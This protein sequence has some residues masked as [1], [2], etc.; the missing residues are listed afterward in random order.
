MNK[1]KKKDFEAFLF[2]FRPATGFLQKKKK[3]KK[4]GEKKITQKSLVLGD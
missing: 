2:M 4:K 3:K 1:E